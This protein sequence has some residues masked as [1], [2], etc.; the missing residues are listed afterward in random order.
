MKRKEESMPKEYIVQWRY[1][2]QEKWY[3]HGVDAVNAPTVFDKLS[4]ARGV[5]EKM[6]SGYYADIYRITDMDGN[7][8][9]EKQGELA[10]RP[11]CLLSPTT[12][13]GPR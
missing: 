10:A 5:F 4:E 12:L 1:R 7:V 9:I 6:V 11:D 2:D 8:V 13:W 3:I